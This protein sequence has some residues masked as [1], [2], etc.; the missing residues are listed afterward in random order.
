VV[1]IDPAALPLSPDE[2]GFRRW[3]AVR[4]PALRRKAYL[5]CGDWYSADDLAQ[6]VLVAVYSK[7][8]RLAG[9]NVD[10]YANRVLFGK[11]VDALRR[12]W[13]RERSVPEQVD[14]VDERA[15]TAFDLVEAGDGTLLRALA[16]LTLDQRSVVVLRFTDDLTI[17]EIARLLGVAPGT[18]KSRLS[19]ALD[20]LRT[21]LGDGVVVPEHEHEETS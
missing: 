5:L 2:A 20:A 6:E 19:R 13:R 7:W 11:H 12:P 4:G 17:D 21:A 16:S 9:G 15:Q 3:M 8:S 1:S 14:R 18:V 10:A